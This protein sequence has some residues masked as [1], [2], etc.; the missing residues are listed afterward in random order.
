MKT[1]KNAGFNLNNFTMP[2]ALKYSPE[3]SSWLGNG[4]TV[5]TDPTNR[6]WRMWNIAGDDASCE[7]CVLIGRKGKEGCFTARLNDDGIIQFLTPEENKVYKEG[8]AFGIYDQ[9]TIEALR[10]R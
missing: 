8:G 3:R 1:I 5:D 10:N 2:T 4:H 6:G 9:A 7:D